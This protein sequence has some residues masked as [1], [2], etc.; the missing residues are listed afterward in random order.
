VPRKYRAVKARASV[1]PPTWWMIQDLQRGPTSPR[2]LDTGERAS[3]L[4]LDE[5]YQR[6]QRRGFE[7]LDEM[8]GYWEANRARLLAEYGGDTV[9]GWWAYRTWG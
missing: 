3:S 7:T 4:S 1:W 9:F 2:Y 8:G 6:S 5:A